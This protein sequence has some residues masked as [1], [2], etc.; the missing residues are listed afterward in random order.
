VPKFLENTLKIVPTYEA[1]RGVGGEL[2]LRRTSDESMY[3]RHCC[4][5]LGLPQYRV[6]PAR[7]FGP[8]D[9]ALVLIL[10]FRRHKI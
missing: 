4:R 6:H 2:G 10:K 5:E 3:D 7:N 9:V 1:G 8:E